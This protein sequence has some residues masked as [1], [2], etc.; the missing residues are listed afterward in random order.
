MQIMTI[1]TMTLC[2][3]QCHDIVQ[4]YVQ[5][6]EVQSYDCTGCQSYVINVYTMHVLSVVLVRL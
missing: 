6:P 4:V 1:D 3:V 2:H 5:G